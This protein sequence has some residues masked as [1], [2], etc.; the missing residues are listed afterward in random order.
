MFKG[1]VNSNLS[2]DEY[3][4]DSVSGVSGGSINSVI[5]S[6]FAKGD[7]KA[8]AERMT[9]FWEDAANAKLY[10]NWFGGIVRGLFFEGGLYDSSPLESFLKKELG[11]I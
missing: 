4:Y 1:I 11:R 5:L 9:K 10:K 8:A 3:A 2:S 7:E 6:D